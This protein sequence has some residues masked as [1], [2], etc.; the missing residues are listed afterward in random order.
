MKSRTA[1]DWDAVRR[2]HRQVARAELWYPSGYVADVPIYKGS[3]TKTLSSGQGQWSGNLETAGYE[4][5]PI[6]DPVNNGWIKVIIAVEESEWVIG[7]FPILTVSEKRPSGGVSVSLS[8]W[9][10][11]RSRSEAESS[12]IINPG[13]SVA[14]TVR[15]YMSHVLPD[16]NTTIE[17]DDSNGA[18]SVSIISQGVGS[19]VWNALTEI[20]NQ[21]GCIVEVPSR[22]TIAIRKYDPYAPYH[23]DV[24]GTVISMVS[25]SD[26]A[27]EALINQVRVFMD[28]ADTETAGDT[29]M[30]EVKITTGPYAFDRNGI[31][32]GVHAEVSRENN[33]SANMAQTIAQ[34]L[35]DRRAG[36]TRR[37]TMDTICQPWLEAGDVIVARVTDTRIEQALINSIKYPLTVDDSMVIGTRDTDIR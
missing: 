29:Y 28:N 2:G 22:N 30:G 19:S 25:T 18:L 20:A 31:G 11:R 3:V 8:D 37:L 6:L 32:F 7:T 1:G 33:P 12:F 21:V 34:R 14:E 24:T 5:Y 13:S 9:S 23:E 4:W 35:F 10:Y 26:V 17:M 27:G 16:P 36:A 15:L